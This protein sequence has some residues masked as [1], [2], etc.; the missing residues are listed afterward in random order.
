MFCIVRDDDGTVEYKT[1]IVKFSSVGHLTLHFPSNYGADNTKVG[2]SPW[3]VL[4]IRLI[5]ISI[6]GITDPDPTFLLYFLYQKYIF[7]KNVCY[8]IYGV[9]IYGRLTKV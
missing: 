2:V 6:R 9:N 4:R 5:L 1:K 8:V 7:Q 3:S